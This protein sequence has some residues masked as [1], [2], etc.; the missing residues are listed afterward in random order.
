MDSK[1][2]KRGR[3]RGR[4]QQSSRAEPRSARSA[5]VPLRDTCSD[6]IILLIFWGRSFGAAGVVFED[7][8]FFNICVFFIWMYGWR[9]RPPIVPKPLRSAQD[10]PGAAPPVP[11]GLPPPAAGG[12]W[13]S[14]G[15]SGGLKGI[16][17]VVLRPS[18]LSPWHARACRA[19]EGRDPIALGYRGK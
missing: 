14:G 17:G 7:F 11:P 12:V 4:G 3:P 15:G 2:K 16:F 9:S 8:F 19:V 18:D 5:R 1:K 6:L 13:G 10:A